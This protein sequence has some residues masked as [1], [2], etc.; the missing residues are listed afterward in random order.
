MSLA[1]SNYTS[2][3]LSTYAASYTSVIALLAA[4]I[5]RGTCVLGLVCLVYLEA[6]AVPAGS[7]DAH[8]AQAPL[9][10]YGSTASIAGVVAGF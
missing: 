4:F 3:M 6:P 7:R 1:Y 8:F 5:I 10:W 9:L 2:A